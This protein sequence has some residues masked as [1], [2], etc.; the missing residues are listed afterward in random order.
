MKWK[1]LFLMNI[2]TILL[3][4]QVNAGFVDWWCDNITLFCSEEKPLTDYNLEIDQTEGI[5]NYYRENNN[6]DIRLEYS[7]DNLTYLK[8]NTNLW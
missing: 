1:L 8:A 5:I 2:I 6:L 4:S 3:V 7:L